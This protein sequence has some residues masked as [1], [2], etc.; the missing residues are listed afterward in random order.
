MA[1]ESLVDNLTIS[2]RQRYSFSVKKSFIR[3]EGLYL[4]MNALSSGQNF[5]FYK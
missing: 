4:C 5:H 1:N 2:R 3:K